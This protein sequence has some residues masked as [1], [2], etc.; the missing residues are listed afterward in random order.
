MGKMRTAH[1]V[2]VERRCVKKPIQR[3]NKY[4]QNDKV[5]GRGYEMLRK[6][7]VGT[8]WDTAAQPAFRGKHV[9]REGLWKEKTPCNPS[10]GR[11]GIKR[12]SNFE[13]LEAV[14]LQTHIILL[15]NFWETT[16]TH[17]ST[18]WTALYKYVILLSWHF[19]C[20]WWRANKQQLHSY[21][22]NYTYAC[23][24]FILLTHFHVGRSQTT[25]CQTRPH[26]IQGCEGLV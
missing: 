1:K 20:T 11:A 24:F 18:L 23:P 12:Q 7:Y 22:H 4:T 8:V 9:A 10:L 25:F 14:Y 13:N 17:Y 26:H 2:Y 21:I 15:V 6:L 16:A 3:Q 19:H 5:R